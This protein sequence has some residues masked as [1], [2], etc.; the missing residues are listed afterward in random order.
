MNHV[1]CPIAIRLVSIPD[2]LV[3]AAGVWAGPRVVCNIAAL[4]D[5]DARCLDCCGFNQRRSCVLVGG[6]GEWSVCLLWCFG[7]ANPDQ[8]R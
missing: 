3:S 6:L 4:L 2:V 7:S 8:H 5:H 1:G